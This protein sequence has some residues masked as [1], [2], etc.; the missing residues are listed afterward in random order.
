MII[1]MSVI[2]MITY[3]FRGIINKDNVVPNIDYG[4]AI[5][6]TV[7]YNTSIQYISIIYM[8]NSQS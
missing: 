6:Y 1:D 3:L 2:I 4:S 5:S 8:Y 7:L